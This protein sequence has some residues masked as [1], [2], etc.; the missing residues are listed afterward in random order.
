MLGQII[1]TGFALALGYG[2]L[3]TVVFY[4]PAILLEN[5]F[6]CLSLLYFGNLIGALC[7]PFIMYYITGLKMGLICGTTTFI[8]WLII[9]NLREFYLIL[10]A[11]LLGG[12][13]C[14]L[15]RSLQQIWIASQKIEDNK[16]GLY[17]GIF[18]GIFMTYGLIGASVS[19][20]SFYFNI[21][22]EYL[23]HI[24]TALCV[25][26]LICLF[27]IN[28]VPM[29]E[30]HYVSLYS[31]YSLI[32][33]YQLWLLIPT[34][35]AQATIVIIASGN[36]PLLIGNNILYLA[37]SMLL[38]SVLNVCTAYTGGYIIDRFGLIPLFIFSFLNVSL[39]SILLYLEKDWCYII[40]CGLFGIGEALCMGIVSYCLTK[41]YKGNKSVFGLYRFVYS[42]FS[43]INAIWIGHVVIYYSLGIIIISLIIGLI[44]NRYFN[45]SPELDPLI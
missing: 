27:F 18:N 17:L 30:H 20:I 8:I 24:M 19:I 16:I 15:T 45:L 10:A 28:N 41:G 11:S 7:S 40:V 44:C 21:S 43:S 1:L 3:G 4:M 23:V 35:F 29:T 36:I 26:S 38:W 2:T 34:I 33:D 42:L 13:G 5:A 12:F 22:L 37:Y 39:I 14:G 6:Y 32:F 25:L 31:Y 9:F